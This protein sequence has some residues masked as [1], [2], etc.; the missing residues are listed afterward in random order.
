MGAY[1]ENAHNLQRL[2]SPLKEA[3]S[4]LRGHMLYSSRQE[5]LSAPKKS[6][7]I[8]GMS[9]LG[10]TVLSN[11]LRQ[12]ADWFHYSVDY[13]IGTRYMSEPIVDNFKREAMKSPLL[14]EL[15]KS[16]S[17][18][19]ASNITFENLAPLS[20]YLGKPG[21]SDKGGIPFKEYCKRQDEH[22][23]AEIHAVKDTAHFHNRASEIYGYQNF[24]VDCSGSLCEIVGDDIS[25]CAIM[26][27]LSQCALPV[28]IEGPESH[29][30][31]LVRRFKKS[32]KPMYYKP[33]FLHTKWQEYLEKNQVSGTKVD[34]D[35]FLVWG[36]EQLLKN[37]LPRY[38][39]MAK[40]WGI[41]VSALE[42]MNV[43]TPANF[44]D[45]IAS[46]LG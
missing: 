10:K 46:K 17:I 32:P 29:N 33:D 38:R 21:A 6:V 9:G 13:R 24:V 26:S 27:A 16:D 35:D 40:N 28:W 36:Y 23:E 8:F 2:I 20:T 1:L 41:T 44:N 42:V 25:N 31:E 14:A 11:M 43:K 30:D 5:Y 4:I 3:I 18:Y 22:R 37:R 7:A 34:P 12:E 45:L 15:L 19:L 39:A